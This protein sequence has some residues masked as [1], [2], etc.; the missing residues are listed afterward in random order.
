VAEDREL[1]KKICDGDVAAFNLL[2]QENAPRLRAFLR[3]ITGSSEA[4]EDIVQETFSAFWKNPGSYEPEQGSLRTW[5]FGI[6]KKRAANWWRKRDPAGP[7][8]DEPASACRLEISSILGD[9]L[10]RLPEQQRV[11]LWLR[12][13]EGQSYEELAAILEIPIGT[14]RSRLFAARDALRRI[15]HQ[16]T[17]DKEVTHEVR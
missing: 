7:Q 2:Y 17:P 15:W 5:L 14:V 11:I 13:V 9:A 16:G 6:S 1:W 3:R 10:A 12:E 8:A 4:A